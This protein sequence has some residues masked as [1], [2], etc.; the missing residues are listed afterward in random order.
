MT[1]NSA[2]FLHRTIKEKNECIKNE[3]THICRAASD[4]GE[5][6]S[7]SAVKQLKLLRHRFLT[8]CS[9]SQALI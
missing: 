5:A 2:S 8:I 9:H 7:A 6:E 1:Q 4:N 3:A